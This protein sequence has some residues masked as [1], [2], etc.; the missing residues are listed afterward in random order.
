[1]DKALQKAIARV[2]AFIAEHPGYTRE[3]APPPTQGHTNRIVFAHHRDQLVVFKICCEKERKERECFGL[4]HWHATGLVPDLIWD[5]DPY[6]LIMGHVPGMWLTTLRNREGETAWRSACVDTGRASAKLILVPLPVESRAEFESRF[7]NKETV[8]DYLTKM[9]QLGRAINA[10]DPDFTG[11]FWS[12]NL[13]FLES[14]IPVLLAQPAAL[15][16]QDIQGYVLNGRFVQFF[17]VEMCRVGCAGMQLGSAFGGIDEGYW[18]LFREGWEEASGH[19]LTEGELAAA[20]AFHTAMG[21]REISRYFT[22]DGT[23]GTGAA[24][25][26]PADP[27]RYRSRVESVRRMLQL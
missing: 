23:P 15:Y 5:D 27:L 21:W 17:D 6:M 4:R 10:R 14:Q 24:W 16:H 8:A 20:A 1:M 25:A 3:G 2:D 12:D 19:R 13:D 22:Y 7:Y 9:L 26:S 11:K 18:P